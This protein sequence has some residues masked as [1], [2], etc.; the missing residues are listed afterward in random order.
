[1]CGGVSIRQRQNSRGSQFS[2]HVWGCFYYANSKL[3]RISVLPTCVGV[4]LR[5]LTIHISH[6]SSPHMCG[7]VSDKPLDEEWVMR[8]S[9]HVWGCFL[10]SYAHSNS[11]DVLPTCVGVFLLVLSRNANRY[12][13]PHMCGGVSLSPDKIGLSNRVLPTCVGVFPSQAKVREPHKCS[14]HMC[15]GVSLMIACSWIEA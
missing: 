15:G 1:M 5:D 14:P 2:P 9:P 4:F 3:P 11:R 8:F 10:L 13:S 6:T 12:C 7:G